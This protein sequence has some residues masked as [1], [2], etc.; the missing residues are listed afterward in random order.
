LEG[1]YDALAAFSP[2]M[3]SALFLAI[4]TRARCR[5]V[6]VDRPRGA[7]AMITRRDLLRSFVATAGVLGSVP[8]Q[9]AGEPP[10]E[11]TKLKG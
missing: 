1:D 5:R 4:A 2:E 6:L 3:A 11:T 10:P 8:G 7:E 9:A